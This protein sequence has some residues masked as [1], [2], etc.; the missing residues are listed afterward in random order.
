MRLADDYTTGLLADGHTRFQLIGYCLGGM[1][2]VEV[3]RRLGERG[4][5]V[6]DLVLASSHPVAFDLDE[7]LMIEAV[8]VPNLG[9]SLD[10]AGF[11]QVDPQAAVSAFERIVQ[12]HGSRMPAGSL[13]ALGG[14]PA[15]DAVGA[16]FR[17]LG[18]RS[19][20]ERFAA[21]ARAAAEV[22]GKAVPVDIVSGLYRVF[23]QSFRAAHFT[24]PPYAD[25]IRFLRPTGP[26]SFAPGLDDTTLAF[27]RE[28]CIGGFDLTDV[29]G[30]HFSCV[31][32]PHVH[33][34]AEHI[35]APLRAARR[36]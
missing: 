36:R 11:G 25:D 6:D 21:Y 24:P 3:A 23:R 13:T 31:E 15:L 20:D 18:E 8:F 7:E 28:V 5:E 33:N 27:W 14:D 10:Q 22:T 26:S 2:A 16:F 30:D 12:E 19:Q 17:R 34:L 9:I 35:A 1:Y 29:G 32:P 4:I